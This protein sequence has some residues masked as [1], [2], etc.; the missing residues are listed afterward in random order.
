MRIDRTTSIQFDRLQRQRYE[1]TIAMIQH[2]DIEFE[3]A[4]HDNNDENNIVCKNN[5][6][7]I[8]DWEQMGKINIA[9]TKSLR[10]SGRQVLL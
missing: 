9:K 5:C 10:P 3:T 1:L 8:V 6:S 7:E 4:Y 2:W